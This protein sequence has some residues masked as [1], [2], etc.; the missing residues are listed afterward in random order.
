M[1]LVGFFGFVKKFVG[2]GELRM[3]LVTD[4]F[5]DLVAAVVNAGPDGGEDVARPGSEISLH[6]ANTLFDDSF[7]CATPT[8]VK[9]PDCVLSL[10]DENDGDT[11]RGLDREQQVGSCGDE[12]VANQMMLGNGF[13][14]VDEIGV[15]LAQGDER[16]V[17]GLKLVEEQPSIIL[18]CG[19]GIVL[20]ESEVQIGFAVSAGRSAFP[21][22]EAVNQPGEFLQG[23]GGKH[24]R[25]CL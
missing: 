13:D 11:I 19:A 17:P 23:I 6:L 9:N 16:P 25:F 10:I 5:S 18:H 15:Y 24:F 7:Y 21:G 2:V 20:G 1:D 3:K 12:A 8:R 22:A 14:P 4:L